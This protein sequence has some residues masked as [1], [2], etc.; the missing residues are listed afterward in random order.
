MRITAQTVVFDAADLE[1]ESSFWARMLGGQVRAE[2]DWHTVVVAG[3]APVAVQ[4][5]PDHRPP[6]WPQGLP[7]QIHLDLDVEDITS[8][9]TEVIG[10]GAEVLQMATGDQ[11]FNV[12]ADPAGHPFCLCWH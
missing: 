9:H 10:L 12:Y 8:A 5:A 11:R 6:Q 3:A 4:S 7:Q 2:T 1:A